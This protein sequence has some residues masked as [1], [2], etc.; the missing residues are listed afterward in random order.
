MSIVIDASA[1]AEVVARTARAA[2]VEA[3][4]SG[5]E[6]IAPDLINAEVLSV[7]RGWLMREELGA[8][9]AERAVGN[10]RRAP[11]RRYPTT[12]LIDD[13]WSLRANVTP[14][15]ACY[16]SLARRTSSPLLS[17]DARLLRAPGLEVRLL[18]A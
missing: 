17:L 14:H 18:T 16:V 3:L 5:E 2:A 15:D 1:L 9:A 6:L 11:I 10:L 4:F 12:A 13:I 7:L 8:A